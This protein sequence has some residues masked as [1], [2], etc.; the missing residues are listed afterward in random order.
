LSRLDLKTIFDVVC[1]QVVDLVD[2]QINEV[3]KKGYNV[4]VRKT[5]L[6]NL[7]LPDSVKQTV[8]LVGGF[9]ANKYLYHRLEALCKSEDRDINVIQLKNA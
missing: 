8:L 7:S 6:C 1:G 9:G 4:K 5:Y 2:K 3:R